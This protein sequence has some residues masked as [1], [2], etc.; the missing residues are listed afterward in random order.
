MFG[1]TTPCV[2]RARDVLQDAGYE[3][4]VFHSTGT[5]GK[6]ME[7]LVKEGLVDA[8]LDIT[9]TEWADTVCGGVFDAGPD[10]MG[11][12]RYTGSEAALD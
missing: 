3:V 7:S 8:V 10:R 4:L 1:V 12:V 11:A 5:G 2:E 6:A 9:T